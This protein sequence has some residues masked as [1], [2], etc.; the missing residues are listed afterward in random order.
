MCVVGPV[1]STEATG[2]L[3]GEARHTH[4]PGGVARAPGPPSSTASPTRLPSRREVDQAADSLRT[5][6]STMERSA[7]GVTVRIRLTEFERQW[8]AAVAKQ[9]RQLAHEHWIK[10]HGRPRPKQKPASPSG[11][12]D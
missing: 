7:A 8:G 10:T 1:L 12:A 2:D 11:R 4:P 3:G 5:T 6:I 9:L